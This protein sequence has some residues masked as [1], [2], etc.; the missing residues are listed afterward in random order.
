MELQHDIEKILKYTFVWLRKFHTTLMDEAKRPKLSPS[1]DIVIEECSNPSGRVQDGEMAKRILPSSTNPEENNDILVGTTNYTQDSNIT[2]KRK[3]LPSCLIKS[4]AKVSSNKSSQKTTSLRQINR[5]RVKWTSAILLIV[6]VFVISSLLA[7]LQLSACGAG[8]GSKDGTGKGS[9]IILEDEDGKRPETGGGYTGP[10][11]LSLNGGSGDSLAIPAA[12]RSAI[13]DTESIATLPREVSPCP[14]TCGNGN[15]D[16]STGKCTCNPGWRGT[17]CSLCGGKIKLDSSK[18]WLAD[19]IGNYTVDSKCTW[20]IEAPQDSK[21]RLHLKDFATECGWDHLYVFDGDSVFSDLTAVYSGMVKSNYYSIQRVPEV[22]GTSGSML[23]H[24]YSD[25]AYNMTGFNITFS[26]NACPSESFDLTCSGHGH[27][28]KETTECV[29]DEDYRGPACNIPACPN[30]C[31]GPSPRVREELG[32]NEFGVC[33]REKKKCECNSGWVGESCSQQV[34]KGF[35]QSIEVANEKISART[36]HASIVDESGSMWVIGGETFSHSK[37]MVS[38]FDL[39]NDGIE[40]Q[41]MWRPVRAKGDKGPSP[42]YGHSAVIHDNKIYMYG[43]TMKSG[44]TSKEVWALDMETLVWQRVETAQGRCMGGRTE[45]HGPH[46][47][48]QGPKL[49]GPI[50]SMGHTA[51]VQTNRM[52]VIFGH[53]PK[54]GYLDTVQEYHFK[55]KEWSVVETSGYPVKGGFGHSAVWDEITKRI[56]VYGGY[57]STASTSAQISKELYS[58]DPITNRWMLHSSP[59]QSGWGGSTGGL[60]PNTASHRYLHSAVISRG[61]MIVFGGNTHNDTSWSQ[62]AKCFSSDVMVYDILCD[63]WY[64]MPVGGTWL[65]GHDGW[66]WRLAGQ[67]WLGE[68]LARY[69]H[70]AIMSDGIMLVYGGFNG[71]LKNDILAYTPG[72]C[73]QFRNRGECLASQVGIKCLWN[74]KLDTCESQPVSQRH[75]SGFDYCLEEFIE[76]QNENKGNGN[77]IRENVNGRGDDTK[78]RP[79]SIWLERNNSDLCGSSDLQISCSACVST[80]HG[81]VWCNVDGKQQCL[82]RSCD[83]ANNRQSRRQGRLSSG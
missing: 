59:D 22:V 27:C 76:T 79:S 54:Y 15:C 13:E 29:C 34:S 83:P 1:K 72:D 61:L 19:A 77:E 18:G 25:V 10:R 8:A 31:E 46:K 71:V 75:K 63:R 66:T 42:R 82:W 41:G 39:S 48:Q 67:N 50:H 74:R 43:G 26:I 3:T 49:C 5:L 4:H 33:N 16:R 60:L 73:T 20:L 45:A 11:T 53:S 78:S 62:G 6:W 35:W 36:S 30:N 32:I 47:G 37:H 17:H 24:F 80:K 81:C 65:A 44:H 21:I 69:G 2:L 70:S 52:I 28:E 55:N 14:P 51:T 40:M 7:T 57:V 64:S 56:Y 58:Y 23:L 9:I 38:K 12:I 68:D